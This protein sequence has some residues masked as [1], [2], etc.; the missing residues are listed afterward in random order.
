[1][2]LEE[3]MD[4]AKSWA[5]GNEQWVVLYDDELDEYSVSPVTH[6]I[7]ALVYPDGRVVRAEA[8]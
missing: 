8:N 6:K 4:R 3:A 1:M 5:I 2:T 7:H